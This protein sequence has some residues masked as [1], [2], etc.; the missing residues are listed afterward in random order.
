MITA[1][2]TPKSRRR[3]LQLSLRT[4]MVLCGSPVFGGQA[5]S[6]VWPVVAC[7]ADTAGGMA[8]AQAVHVGLRDFNG[9]K[10]EVSQTGNLVQQREVTIIEGP[11][12]SVPPL[13]HDDLFIFTTRRQHVR[14]KADRDPSVPNVNRPADGSYF[15]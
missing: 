10:V 4:M 11:P 15:H 6:A 12:A 13:D 3:W 1:P 2:T 14:A 7:A 8:L 9:V 5:S